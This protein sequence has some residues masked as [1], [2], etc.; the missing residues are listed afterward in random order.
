MTK[1]LVTGSDGQL[2]RCIQKI[3]VNYTNL[4]FVFHNSKSLDISNTKKI[5]EVFSTTSFDYCI[6]CAAYTNVEQSEKTPE[7][8]YLVN[9]KAVNHISR[10]CA[11][12]SVK[13]I[14]IS[15]DYVFDGE[16]GTPYLTS[17]KT[18]PINEYGKSKL[19]GEKNIQQT[20]KEYFIVRTSWLYSEFG[21]NFYKTIVQKAKTESVLQITDA[22]VGSPTNANNL[23]KYLIDLIANNS[24]DYGIHHFTDGEAMTWYDFARNILKENGLQDKV[25]LIKAENFRTLAKRPKNSI[26]Q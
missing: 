1:I 14:H 10:A 5:A 12:N 16:K 26:L 11:E 7:A 2:G 23:A 4:D 20:L 15:T 3:A 22:Q 8:A 24:E 13:L 6:N 19:V 25:K 18:N 21:K 9:A 17:D